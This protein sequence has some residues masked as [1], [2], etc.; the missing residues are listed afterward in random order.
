[1]KR[2]VKT[3]LDKSVAS[4]LL[5]I[6]LF[7]RPHDYARTCSV[8]ILLDHSFE[9]LLK[10]SILQKKGRIFDK[11]SNYTIGFEKCLRI[12]VG[13]GNVRF[14]TKEQVLTLQTINSIRDAQQ[15][16]I[17]DVSE[18]QLYLY[19]QSGFTL[20]R[21]ILRNVFDKDLYEFLPTRVLPI[22]TT[23]PMS[24]EVLFD[25]EIEE[26]KRL[27][28]AKSRKK[29]IAISKLKPLE[30]LE[31]SLQG[32][33]QPVTDHDLKKKIERVQQEKDWRTVFPNVAAIEVVPDSSSP[34]IALRFTK[35]EGIPIHVVPEGTPGSFVVA[36]K[37][38]NELGFFNMTY[39][40]LA[41]AIHQNTAKTNALIWYLK[42]KN[43]DECCKAIQM[44]KTTFYKYSV[45][46]ISKIK[47]ALQKT[48]IDEIWKTYRESV[49]KR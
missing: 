24:L 28:S 45:K 14:L 15:H 5:S 38:V 29:S 23:P 49:L 16:Y 40:Q 9:M 41:E 10:A 32:N 36:I 21:D 42:I 6:E 39:S 27:L 44:G 43:D 47:D 26:I 22:S 8:L 2:E 34:S 7:N 12:A 35:K 3:L 17:I 37:K 25:Q 1:M 31:R 33:D 19:V 30:I 18:N 11:I 48:T 13:D 46:S 4:L 20:Y